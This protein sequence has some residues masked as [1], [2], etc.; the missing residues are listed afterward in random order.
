MNILNKVTGIFK[1]KSLGDTSFTYGGLEILNQLISSGKWGK[2]EM[3]KQYEKSMYVFACT[4]KIAEKVAS[5]DLNLYQILNVKGDVREINNHPALDLLYKVNPFQTKS[6]FL[7]IT[8]VNKKLCGDAFWYKVK[9]N[10]GQVIELWNLRPDRM[11]IVK[12]DTEFI[13]GYELNKTNGKKEFFRPDEI[14]H[15][16]Y[17]TPLDDWFGASPLSAAKVR[18][19]TESSA[20]EYQKNFFLNN[21]RPDGVLKVNGGMAL[22]KQQKTEIKREFEKRHRGTKNNSR[23]AVL[24]GDLEYQQISISQREM[25]FIESMKFTRDDILV[26][27]GVPK[28]IVAITDDVNRANAETSMY[29]FL[30]E[31]IRPELEMLTE[32]INEMLIIPDFGEQFYLDFVDPTPENREQKIKEYETGLKNGYLLINEV[33]AEESL[34]PIEGG[35]SLYKPLNEIPVG[36]LT[37]SAQRKFI[38]EWIE[39]KNQEKNNKKMKI[40]CGRKQLYATMELKEAFKKTKAFK[41]LA[42]QKTEERTPLIK[43]GIRVDYAK[44]VNKQIDNRSQEF[45]LKIDE[46]ATKQRARLK[47]ELKGSTIKKKAGEDVKGKVKSFYKAEIPLTA[48]FS[49][50]FIEEYMREAGLEAMMLVNPNESF[51]M[52]EGARVNMQKRAEL[53]ATEVSKT[54]RDKVLRQIQEG[55]NNGEGM[56]EISERI[57][58]TYKEFPTWRSDLIARTESTV[59]NNEGFIEAYKQSKVVEYKEWI[60]VMDDRTRPEHAAMDGEIVEVNQSFSNGLQYPQEPNCRCVIAPAL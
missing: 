51:D 41:E 35:W 20:S 29:I 55:I 8:M 31:V 50:P 44:M 52:N 49:F 11:E 3:L 23:I 59:A 5:T 60:A 36:G 34:E 53:M 6:E 45:K 46:F 18:I 13:L 15:F 32:K 24:E 4:Y 25:D 9:D 7:K 40:F 43:E 54:T 42:T 16:K 2:E 33:R 56:R 10:R 47:T 30:S 19:E 21:A 14:V 1:R 12:S 48:E 28:A 39:S 58:E 26:A 57:S 37:K 27:F 17:P 22:S 38:T